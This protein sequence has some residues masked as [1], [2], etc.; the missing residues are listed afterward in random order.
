[1][2]RIAILYPNTDGARFD[3]DYYANTHMPMAIALLSAHR[4]FRGV[5][6]E[7]GVGGAVPGAAPA[8]IAMCHYLFDSIEEFMA[9]FIPNAPQL[10]GDM[11]NYTDI[12]PLIQF[13]EVLLASQFQMAQ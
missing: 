6:V 1:M 5:S 10:Q 8:Y 2:I 13:N 3:L 4:G 9:A 11:R 7:R 12:E